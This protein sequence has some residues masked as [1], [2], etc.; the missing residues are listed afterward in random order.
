[1]NTYNKK[2]FN[3]K[4]IFNNSKGQSTAEI[5]CAYFIVFWGCVG[6]IFCL[7]YRVN[8]VVHAITF[9]A[10]GTGMFVARRFKER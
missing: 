1:M 7:I 2:N 9:T 4:E 5:L 10:L 3:I 8:L 6:F